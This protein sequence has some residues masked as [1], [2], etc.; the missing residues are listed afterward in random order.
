VIPL[1]DLPEP[2][3]PPSN[4]FATRWI[5]PGAITFQFPV[6]QSL[7]GLV[8][9]LV[10]DDWWGQIVGPHGS[11]KSTLL[12]TLLPA[13]LDAGRRIVRYDLHDRQRR[14]PDHAPATDAWDASTLVVIDG[15]EQLSY[16]ARWQLRRACR[17]RGSGL[18][19]TSHRRQ[20]LPVLMETATSERLLR[21]LVMMLQS[22]QE[23]SSTG[24]MVSTAEIDTAFHQQRGN[25]REALLQ[26]YDLHQQRLQ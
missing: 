25:L 6:G 2:I 10:A 23:A 24:S 21:S 26:L 12:A 20:G 15:Y 11:G 7:S 8:T 4:P 13:C 9:Q 1:S 5:R 16:F 19:I 14:L 22:R 18:L 3:H 17:R